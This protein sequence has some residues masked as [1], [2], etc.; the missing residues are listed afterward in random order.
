MVNLVKDVMFYIRI[1]PI[2]KTHCLS[3]DIKILRQNHFNWIV[4]SFWINENEW[5]EM[6]LYNFNLANQSKNR[7]KQYNHIGFLLDT[8]G[9]DITDV[10]KWY[11]FSLLKTIPH[12]ICISCSKKLNW[13]VHSWVFKRTMCL[14]FTE[15]GWWYFK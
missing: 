15:I 3:C 14:H 1:N 2:I 12:N 9:Y 11:S 8:R 7:E 4:K 13:I 10:Q 5:K 6:S